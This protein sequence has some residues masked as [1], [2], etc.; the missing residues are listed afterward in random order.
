MAWHWLFSHG[1]VSAALCAIDRDAN[2]KA[3]VKRTLVVNIIV[4]V[5]CLELES[6]LSKIDYNGLE[7]TNCHLLR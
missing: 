5:C 6:F 2:A 1:L 7:L 3:I 4:S